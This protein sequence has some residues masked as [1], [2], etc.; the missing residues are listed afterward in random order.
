MSKMNTPQLVARLA[1][2]TGT[3]N[4]LSETFVRAFIETVIAKVNEDGTAK[5]QGFGVF[6]TQSVA[7]RESVNV[8]TGQ[9]FTI[10]GYNKLVFTPDPAV[11]SI[12]ADLIPALPPQPQNEEAVDQAP[13]KTDEAPTSVAEDDTPAEEPVSQTEEPVSLIEEP[14]T[15]AEEPATPTEEPVSPTEEPTSMTEELATEEPIPVAEEI[16]AM[17]EPAPD[18]V[19]EEPPVVVEEVVEEVAEEPSA[20]VEEVPEE[21]VEETPA[22]VDEEPEAAEELQEEEVEEIPVS[23]TETQNEADAVE[24]VTA[25]EPEAVTEGADAVVEQPEVVTEVPKAVAAV[26]EVVS[27]AEPVASEPEAA[28]ETET[29]T[30]SD[31]EQVST[32]PFKAHKGLWMILA[33][34]I[35]ALVIIAI[36]LATD[37]YIQ[38]TG[39]QAEATAV[40]TPTVSHDQTDEPKRKVHILQKGESLT[41][42]SVAYYQTPDSMRAIWKLNKFE[43]PNNI[44]LGT[45]IL[46][47]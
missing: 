11:A 36:E 3:T 21:V 31:D 32:S 47:P 12:F 16:P 5:V 28:D 8:S 38:P 35:V 22:V 27:E 23:E 41:T 33:A 42:I 29:D 14:A 2:A 7:D 25:A 18:M 30:V 9:R 26:P 37:D 19:T 15:Q 34:V 46:L 20:D 45:E 40:E 43:D 39:M 6:K 10:A 1:S 24:G 13:A 44:P 4:R 17:A